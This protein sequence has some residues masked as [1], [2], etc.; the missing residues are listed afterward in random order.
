MDDILT[1][2]QLATELGIPRGTL[3]RALREDAPDLRV[4]LLPQA[5]APSG[6]RGGVRGAWGVRSEDVEMVKEILAV[7][8]RR[9]GKGRVKTPISADN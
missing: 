4:E 9:L 2:A 8:R 5:P 7:R 6:Q 3:A 1:L